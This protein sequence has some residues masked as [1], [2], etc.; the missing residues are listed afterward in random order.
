MDKALDL[1]GLQTKPAVPDMSS[2]DMQ[3]LPSLPKA[4]KKV[5][6][7]IHA[8][9]VLNTDTSGRSLSLVAKIYK[10]TDADPFLQAPYD[11]LKDSGGKAAAL[12]GVLDVREV[13]L[14]PGQKYEV[15]ETL[16]PEVTHVAIVGL[17]RAPDEK[18]WRF[19]FDAKAVAKTGITMGAH[20]CALSVSEGQ[21]VGAPV[22]TMRLAGVRCR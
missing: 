8:G 17:F 13:V 21:P 10:L 3:N 20:G 9:E 4:S 19:A 2:I 18:R 16:P 11:A 12:Q 15:V 7:R 22:E 14:T 5:T 1:V 6:L